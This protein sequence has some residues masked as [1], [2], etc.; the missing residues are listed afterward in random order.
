MSR[1]ITGLT[2]GQPATMADYRQL[3]TSVMRPA[4]FSAEEAGYQIPGK[5]MP[6]CGGCAHYF[7]NPVN[8]SK[9]CEVVRLAG[10]RNISSLMTCRFQNRDGR[11]YPLLQ[12]L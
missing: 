10:E 5:G 12:I 1:A 7:V 9:V 3:F 6:R 8:G 2:G 11:S 4:K